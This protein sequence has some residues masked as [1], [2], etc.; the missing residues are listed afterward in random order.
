MSSEPTTSVLTAR[1]VVAAL[2]E[3]GGDAARILGSARISR[4]ALASVDNRLPSGSVRKL[5]EA[6]A[7]AVHDP[8]F[9]VHLAETLPAGAYDVFE[10]ILAAADSVGE[11]FSRLARYF[12]LFQDHATLKVV[13]E[14]G[15]ARLVRRGPSLGPH[16]DEFTF[17]VIVLRS[18]LASTVAWSPERVSFRHV[19]KRDDGEPARVFGCPVLFG[20][21]E[22][23]MSFAPSVLALPHPRADSA[24]LEVLCSRMEARLRSVPGPGALL[25]RVSAAIA[26]VIR[27][28]PPTLAATAAAVRI[29]ERTLQ[30]RLADEGVSHSALVD[31]VRRN[32]ALEYLGDA[33][34]SV[35][36]IAYRLQF[37]DPPTFYRAFK[38]WT[39]ESP[40]SYRKRF[41]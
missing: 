23:E 30:R 25:A 29:P 35:T 24:L 1:P 21:A 27:T 7:R 6:A 9:G 8:S 22:T 10:H 11:G 18:R 36:E 39:G 38:R 17:A 28:E 4:E 33:S 19:R 26:R 31:D 2:E 34:L 16:C 37:A 3:R 13:L 15:R 41:L 32:L 12:P 40:L 20:G 5:W 14:P